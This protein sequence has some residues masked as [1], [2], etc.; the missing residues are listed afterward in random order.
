MLPSKCTQ[1]IT[2]NLSPN[3]PKIIPLI[4]LIS[5][6]RKQYKFQQHFPLFSLLF[7]PNSAPNF[8]S[9]QLQSQP[10]VISYQIHLIKG[11][12]P[13]PNSQF[14]AQISTTIKLNFGNP[15]LKFQ[16]QAEIFLKQAKLTYKIQINHM[17]KLSN[18]GQTQAS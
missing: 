14:I 7:H 8:I 11:I 3:Q 6:E 13:S 18:H 4:S 17:T 9:I 1:E 12:K 5:Q 2:C 10:Q 15:K 16:L